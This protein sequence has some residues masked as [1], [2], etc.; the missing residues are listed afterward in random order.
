MSVFPAPFKKLNTKIKE[1]LEHLEI[2]TPTPFQ[3]KSI[4]VIKSGAN[5]FC[6]AQK[7]SGKTFTLVLTTLQKIKYVAEGTSP[8]A[9]IVV[10]N[11]EKAS[12][13]YDAFL[14]F[15]RYSSVRVYV[16]NEKD[17][18]DLQKSEIFEGVDVL[19]A[20]YKSLNKLFLL[21]GVSTSQVKM[22]AID[23]AEFLSQKQA[24]STILSITQSLPK[25]QFVIYSEK[26]Q[27]SLSR[28]EDY[29][30]EY[31]KIVSE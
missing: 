22:F 9:M 4:P 3:I 11:T 12:E 30:M 15:T 16:A 27:P 8:R 19:I 17:H 26:M 25:C 13:L 28:L 7:G 21:N 6:T 10:E 2:T 14:K 5:V 18:V 20:T 29:F 23:D 24:Y 1:V 31:S